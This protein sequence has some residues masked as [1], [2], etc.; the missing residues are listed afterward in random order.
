MQ[1]TKC[2]RIR[3]DVDREMS[4]QILRQT[5]IVEL[6]K[7]AEVDWTKNSHCFR[8]IGFLL[9]PKFAMLSF[10][11]AFESLR[12]ANVL[13][14]RELT[15][16]H[17]LSQDGGP[18]EAAS[19]MQVVAEAS[20]SEMH[21]LPTVIIC[22]GYDPMAGVSGDLVNWLRRLDRFGTVL[23]T[24]GSGCHVLAESSLLNGSTVTMHWEY[25]SAFNERFPD[26]TVSRNL[27][28]VGHNRFSCS[29][30][31]AAMDFMIY[32][33]AHMHGKKLALAVSEQ[34][35]HEP[36]RG[37]YDQ[38]RVDLQTVYGV[39]SSAIQEVVHLMQQNLETPIPIDQL[40][41]NVSLTRRQL[42]RL[43]SE[44]LNQTPIQY[45]L[46]LRIAKARQLLQQTDLKVI[47]VA[48]ACGFN[49]LAHFSRSY[50]GATGRS[51]RE[52]RQWISL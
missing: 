8:E 36:I 45:Y 31:T 13:S 5:R 43:F 3:C 19:G 21:D 2:R 15:K 42:Q 11:A 49:S 38:Q 32:M 18:V 41:K 35:V 40:A 12:V 17:I 4:A 51:P 29:G 24:L 33:I 47:D 16:I 37:P 7:Q 22:S 1:L 20:I 25:I 10:I 52:D 9:L 28:E 30:G 48:V 39:H 44:Y 46:S 6:M 14:S 23:G 26:I 27:F 50:R 34:F